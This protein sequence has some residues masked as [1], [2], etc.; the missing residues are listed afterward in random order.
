MPPASALKIGFGACALAIGWKLR[1]SPVATQEHLIVDAPNKHDEGNNQSSEVHLQKCETTIDP[2]FAN[3]VLR[4][5]IEAF[6]GLQ[7]KEA[8]AHLKQLLNTIVLLADE[9]QFLSASKMNRQVEAVTQHTSLMI[10]RAKSGNLNDTL[11][12]ACIRCEDDI[13]PLLSTVLNRIY[14]MLY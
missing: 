5:I 10:N 4:R 8:N 14:I 13:V 6:E 3:P 1:G 11:V 7:Q 2:L 12:E 9:R